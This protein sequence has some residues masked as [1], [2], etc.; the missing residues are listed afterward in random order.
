MGKYNTFTPG[1]QKSKNEP[2]EGWKT[3]GCLMMLFVPAVS[4]AAG[5]ATVNWMIKMKVG[6]IPYGWLGYA[7]MPSF[8]AGSSGLRTMFSWLFGIENLYAHIVASI[9]FMLVISS[10]ILIVYSIVYS[11][12]GPS[13]YGPLDAP[14]E[15]IK[16]TKKSR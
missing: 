3:V 4:I 6:R 15:D 10:V 2:R 14:P 16:V 11:I 5:Y 12:V 7:R 1:P 9:I 13:R 8:I